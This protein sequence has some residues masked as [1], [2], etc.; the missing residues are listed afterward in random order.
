MILA[1][2]GTITTRRNDSLLI[3]LS[4]GCQL[5]SRSLFA[6]QSLGQNMLLS[7]EGF[8]NLPW[9]ILVAIF[10]GAKPRGE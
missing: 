9:L 6:K 3:A 7:A 5:M 8:A 2:S 10:F 4:K 1:L